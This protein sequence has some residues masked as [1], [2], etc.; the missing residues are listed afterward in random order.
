[1]SFATFVVS[2]FLPLME[3]AAV[4][5]VFASTRDFGAC[6]RRLVD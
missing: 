4:A 2:L 5:M 1:V 6:G 3:L